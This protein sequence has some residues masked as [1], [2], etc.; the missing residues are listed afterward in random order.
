GA[1]F[2]GVLG[3]DFFFRNYC[4]I[5]C[6]NRRLYVRSSIP[7]EDTTQAIE[8]TLRG[9]GFS[10]VPI[11]LNHGLALAV[12]AKV[13]NETFKLFVDTGGVVSILDSSLAKRLGLAAVK[14]DDAALGSLMK[15][16]I[17]TKV[18]GV[19]KIG[20]H[21]MWFTTLQKLEVGSL[22]WTNVSVGVTSLTNWGL[23]VPG[24]E[25]DDVKG[26]LGRDALTGRGAL[27]D[28]HSRTLW[29]WP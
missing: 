8:K 2:D 1:E 16:E 7:S 4:L 6:F 26:V 15:R 11:D 12:E 18:I 13:K 22:Q 20:A 21:K 5:D 17:S 23:A 29:F 3:C 25:S 19:G 14:D 24:S 10:S 27:I 28:Y 9:S